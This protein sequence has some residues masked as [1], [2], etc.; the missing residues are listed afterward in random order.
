M[1]VNSSAVT[2]AARPRGTSLSILGNGED[3]DNDAPGSVWCSNP[4]GR[5]DKVSYNTAENLLQFCDGGGGIA[6][7]KK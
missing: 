2:A 4:A 7:G 1:W 5:P 3:R 6:V